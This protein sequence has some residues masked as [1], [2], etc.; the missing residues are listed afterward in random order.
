[1]R[2]SGER[3]VTAPVA[4]V[5]E[6]LHDHDVLRSIIPGCADMTPLVG[7]TYSATM[8][9]RVGPI[10]DTYRGSFS[11]TDLRQ[12]SDLRVRVRAGGRFGRLHVDLAVALD[13]GR[14]RRTTA[15]RY[16]ADAAVG[17]VVSRLGKATLT[18]AGG[19]FTGCFFRDLERSLLHG[20]SARQLAPLG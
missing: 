19:H 14:D 20:H 4:T 13:E 12:G 18:V 8:E 6:A 1:M 3:Q 17:G 11:I 5:W 9:A 15:L 7:G 10:A 16:D 2:F